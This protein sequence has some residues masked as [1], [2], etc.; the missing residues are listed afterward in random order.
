MDTNMAMSVPPRGVVGQGAMPELGETT[1]L[2]GTGARHAALDD[3]GMTRDA[4]ASLGAIISRLDGRDDAD[5]SR[6]ASRPS[7]C[8]LD[9][10]VPE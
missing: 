1:A 7:G 5:G 9:F 10:D 2:E 6:L 4:G 8:T 3:T